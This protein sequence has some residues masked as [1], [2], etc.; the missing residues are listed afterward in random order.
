MEISVRKTTMESE[1]RTG[2]TPFTRRIRRGVFR[3]NG[4][5]G[6]QKTTGP[7]ETGVLLG[8]KNGQGGGKI[9]CASGPDTAISEG[10]K[11][12]GGC[13]NESHEAKGRVVGRPSSGLKNLKTRRKNRRPVGNGAIPNSTKETKT[14]GEPSERC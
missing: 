8:D 14:L 3:L 1:N 6:K 10:G 5:G 13:E 9:D 2:K 4:E 12:E 11:R 7:G